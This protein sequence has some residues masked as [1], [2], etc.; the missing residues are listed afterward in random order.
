MNYKLN[1]R[2][3]QWH[4]NLSKNMVWLVFFA[5][6]RFGEIAVNLHILYR[7]LQIWIE[8][9]VCRFG[10]LQIHW[11]QNVLFL[12]ICCALDCIKKP[13]TIKLRNVSIRRW[14]ACAST[15]FGWLRYVFCFSLHFCLFHSSVFNV[16]KW[17]RRKENAH[18][19]SK[20]IGLM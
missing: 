3:W 9:L 14:I 5:F 6:L 16:L 19:N 11:V 1:G 17:I 10:K 18:E 2:R 12:C 7:I 8:H 15:N 4:E 20:Q 13:W